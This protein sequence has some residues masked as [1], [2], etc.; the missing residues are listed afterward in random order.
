LKK[1]SAFDS[2]VLK[3][4]RVAGCP[5]PS[6]EWD[7]LPCDVRILVQKSGTKVYDKKNAAE[8]TFDVTIVNCS[9]GVVEIQRFDCRLPWHPRS[10]RLLSPRNDVSQER[11]YRLPSGREF[12]RGMV[13]NHR[14]G[15]LGILKPQERLQGFL[16]GHCIRRCIPRDILAGST[17]PGEISILD[18]HGR[19]L[20]FDIEV[21]VDR[22]ATMKII[23]TKRPVGSG[24]YDSCGSNMPSDI[25]DTRAILSGPL[26]DDPTSS[27]VILRSQGI[28]AKVHRMDQTEHS[29]L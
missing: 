20:S 26:R 15:P 1:R 2:S 13:L 17:V 23:G 16:L 8:Y 22:S 6:N 11:A 10:V 4:L 29:N 18:Q 9:Y 3:A 27:D 19:W 7:A 28:R 25:P 24:L 14:V 5:V 12:A 21:E